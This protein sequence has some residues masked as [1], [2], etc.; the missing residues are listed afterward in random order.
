MVTPMITPSPALA[1]NSSALTT[2]NDCSRG[3][4]RPSANNPFRDNLITILNIPKSLSERP[5]GNV[6]IRLAWGKYQGIQAAK[7]LFYRMKNDGTWTESQV[8]A[9]DIVELFVSKTVFHRSYQRLFPQA[10]NFPELKAWLEQGLDAPSDRDVWDNVKSIYTFADL[11]KILER[12]EKKVKK[13]K[14]KADEEGAE[15]KSHKK[16]KNASRNT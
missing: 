10:S 7:S 15:G 16:T 11:E 13:A 1:P 8:L 12:L 14:R 6:D 3:R 5:K 9:D 2:S 4:T